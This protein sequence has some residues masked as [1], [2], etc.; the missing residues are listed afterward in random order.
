VN[1]AAGIVATPDGP[2]VAV[3]GFTVRHDRIV[4]I[5]ILAG[6]TRLRRL[7]LAP[8]TTDTQGLGHAGDARLILGATAASTRRT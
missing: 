1:G 7:D 6:P 2:R 3:L 8:W 4:E 5:D